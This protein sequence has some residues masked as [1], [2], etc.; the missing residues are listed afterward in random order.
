MQWCFGT[1]EVLRGSGKTS[2]HIA[3]S[4]CSAIGALPPFVVLRDPKYRALRAQDC[5]QLHPNLL[6]LSDVTSSV[7]CHVL[8]MSPSS[9]LLEFC[10]HY[11]ARVSV[12]VVHSSSY[13]YH[14]AD[15]TPVN[16][17]VLMGPVWSI[18]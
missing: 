17:R 10:Y 15:S 2:V 1:R 16:H 18:I 11:L 14:G 7:F 12:H 5:H 6:Y 8:V 3:S 13:C 4:L 9:S